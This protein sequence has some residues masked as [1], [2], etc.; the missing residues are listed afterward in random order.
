MDESLDRLV[1]TWDLIRPVPPESAH[2]SRP[3]AGRLGSLAGAKG[4]FLDNSKDNASQLLRDLARFLRVEFF[5]GDASFFS[6]PMHTR[7]APGSQIQQ[8]AQRDFAVVAIGD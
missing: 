8:A 3:L 1:A 5:I 2:R 6:K 7:G 4:A